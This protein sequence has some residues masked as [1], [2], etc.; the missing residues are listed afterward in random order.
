MSKEIQSVHDFNVSKYLKVIVR[1]D[2]FG[3]VGLFALVPLQEDEFIFDLRGAV[4][5]PKNRL[6]NL[7]K[8]QLDIV[9]RYGLLSQEDDSLILPGK[10]PNFYWYLNHS[11]KP[12]VYFDGYTFKALRQI[13]VGEELVI[14]YATLDHRTDEIYNF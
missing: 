9:Y 7:H 3:G 11:I 14:D 5:V 6:G 13:E 2:A 1:P 8:N 4:K 12:N 10:Q